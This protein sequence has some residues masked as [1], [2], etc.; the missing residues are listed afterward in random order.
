MEKLEDALREVEELRRDLGAEV[1]VQEGRGHY[2]T[3]IHGHY[4][5]GG[6]YREEEFYVVDEERITCPDEEKRRAARIKLER[7]SDTSE[8]FSTRYLAK[9][10]ISE[11]NPDIISKFLSLIER[12]RG[13]LNA[14]VYED[15]TGVGTV[16]S[17][18]NQYGPPLQ[19]FIPDVDTNNRA[20]MELTAIYNYVPYDDIRKTVGDLL[21][22]REP[23]FPW[24]NSLDNDFFKKLGIFL[25]GALFAG[26]ASGIGYFL[27][28]YFKR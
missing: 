7:I 15:E 24:I 2:E 23:L 27:Y 14:G 16:H 20:R 3:E 4:S 5:S 19:R 22:Y 25:S 28:Q 6:T 21:G 18:Y 1:V 10:I 8:W 17:S 13:D 9:K 26:A 12:L 11:E